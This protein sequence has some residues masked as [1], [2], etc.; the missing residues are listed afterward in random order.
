MSAQY[1]DRNNNALVVPVRN[2]KLKGRGNIVLEARRFISLRTPGKEMV[3]FFTR[4]VV[5]MNY[6][7]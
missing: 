7:L 3:N 2:P 4:T 5:M 1:T 6:D